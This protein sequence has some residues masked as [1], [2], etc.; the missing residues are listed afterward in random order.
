[1]FTV[2]QFDGQVYLAPDR[3][4]GTSLIVLDDGRVL[5]VEGWAG[6]QE[7]ALPHHLRVVEHALNGRTPEEIA[8]KL[9]G[10]V[11]IRISRH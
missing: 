7:F 10:V 3:A 8:Y 1:M 6:N 4:Y 9:N 11:A 5:S 2:F